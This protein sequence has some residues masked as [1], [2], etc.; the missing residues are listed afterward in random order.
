VADRVARAQD[1]AG[2]PTNGIGPGA[3][4][5]DQANSTTN[6][7]ALKQLSVEELMQ[8]EV[9]VVYAASKH[10]Q[11][12]TDAPSSVTIITREEIQDHGY[13]TLAEILNSVPGMYTRTDRNYTFL[14]IRGFGLPGDD[15]SSFLLLVDG[16]RMNDP[17]TDTAL[18]E[19][20]FALNVDMIQRVEVVMGPGA[21]LYGDSAF[22]AVINVIT[23]KGGDVG[24]G[25]VS[26]SGGSLDTYTGRF[27]YGRKFTNGLEAA[28]SGS[29]FSS[30]GYPS[31][32]YAE[33]N[34]PT[35]NNGYADHSD[36]EWGESLFSSV[37][38][39]DLSLEGGYIGRTKLIPTA[40][41]GVAFDDPDTR[42]E[43]NHGY[44][45]LKYEHVFDDDLDVLARLGYDRTREIGTY[46]T[47]AG[48]PAPVL[49][50]D[51]FE[52]QRVT[53]DVQLRRTF[54]TSHLV[55]AGAQMVDNL[56]QNQNNYNVSPPQTFLDDHRHGVD[57]SFF[58]QDEYQ[59]CKQLIFN[60]GVRYDDFYT[61]GSTVN[62]RLALIYQPQ[63]TTSL[64]LIYGTAYRAPTP[65][66]LYYNDGGQT[67]VAN[68]GLRPETI[69][70][71][72]L[73]GEQQIGRHLAASVSG[74]YY[75]IHDLIDSVT[76]PPGNPNAGLIQLQNLG[77]ANAEGVEMALRGDWADRIEG[78]AS[79]SLTAARDG[80]TGARLP[81]SP[82][83]LAKLDLDVP[84][85]GRKL[86]AGLEVLYESE[87]QTLAGQTADGFATVNFTLF[88][89]EL[90]K[91]LEIS[92]SV[93][94][95]FDVHYSEPAGPQ[96]I[97]DVIQQDGR[98]FQVK[99]TCKF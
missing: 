83:A 26:G 65:Y 57:Y 44:A 29:Y 54:F 96:Y 89:Q 12:T 84:I 77:S 21:S 95:L 4:A 51:D 22:F 38:W 82:L 5:E 88:S 72:E 37:S 74:F 28:I 53:G 43:D 9:P 18:I 34:S 90:V 10:E 46:A 16:H 87:R 23:R 70:T 73:V 78:R 97:Q 99:L 39:Q 32:Y 36:V 13:R 69:A 8:V 31:L 15:N 50:I 25:E 94:N 41:Y 98:N 92:G 66:E 17:V 91:G 20:G 62:P 56:D 59:I 48:L 19:N 76:I 24:G 1:E 86:V 6:I 60:G 64:K 49:N 30:G 93:Y 61:F 33:F 85:D 75:D 27:S 47:Y 71:Y 40:P 14:G 81:N 67:Q 58:L 42:T 68:P 11:K 80:V 79:C 7:A 45:D 3:V 2:S 63:A 52:S 35:N 55:T